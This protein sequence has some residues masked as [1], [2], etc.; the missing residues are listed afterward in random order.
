[1]PD[2]AGARNTVSQSA[3]TA[4]GLAAQLQQA[5]AALATERARLAQ[6]TAQGDAQA[7]ADA[8]A[9]IAGLAGQ[10]AE[11][12]RAITALHEST[13]LAVD[14]LLGR[15][16]ALEGQTPLVL[17]PVRI[18]TRSTIDG[19]ALRVRIYHDALHGEA[20]DEGIDPAE[21]EA[22]IAYWT[23]VWPDGDLA[24]PWPALVKAVGRLRAP[25]VAE[26]L[27]PKNLDGRPAG[28][29]AFRDTNPR[30]GRPIT[31]RTLPD[32]FFVRVEQQ[33][34][35]PVTVAGG[36]IPDELPLGLTSRDELTP[37]ELDGQDLPPID[38]SLRWLVDF[39]EAERV[40][41]AVTVPLPVPGGPV[42]RVLVY[43]VRAA[44]SPADGAARLERMIH[45]HRFSDGAMFLAQGTP[46]N[47]TDTVRTDF[48]RRLDPD[49]PG[50]PEALAPDSNAAVTATALGI[51]QD[52]LA[53]LSGAGDQEQGRASA[54]NA[55]LWATTWGDAIEYLT[56]QGRANGDQR[57]DTPALEAVRDHWVAH[58]RG[59]GPLPVLRLGRQPY[60]LLPLVE[61]GAAWQP[62]D[63][64][65][66]ENRLVPFID[67]QI[68]W[69][70]RDADANTPTVMNQPLEQGLKTILGTDAVLRGLR[71]RTALS[72]DSVMMGGLALL[73]PDLGDTASKQQI[74]QTVL[75]LAGIPN[76][77]LDNHHLLGD[78]TR[79][80]ALALVDDTDPA[81]VANLL[82]D[83]PAP[84]TPKSVLQVLLTHADAV[85]RHSR[86][87]VAPGDA[88]G[89]LRQVLEG[90]QNVDRDLAA[91]GI[92]AALNQRVGDPVIAAAAKAVT[93]AAGRL[94]LRATADLE[95]IPAHAQPTLAQQIAGPALDAGRLNG[96]V[97][98]QLI[99]ELLHRA[100]WGATFRKALQTIAAV[101]DLEERRLLLG[102]TLDC[103][104]H[105]LDAW[106]TA[107]ATRRLAD[108]RARNG[109]GAFLGAYGWVQDFAPTVPVSLG[110]VDGHELFQDPHDGG[111]IHAP[112][113]THAVTAGVLRSARLTHARNDPD[114]APLDMD[115]SSTRVRDALSL[116]EGMRNGQTLSALLGYRLERRLHENQLERFIYVL[117]ALA[118]TRA[119]KL[120][121][122]GAPAQESLA[123]R[124]VVDGLRLLEMFEK[125]DNPIPQKLREGPSDARYIDRWNSATDH[126]VEAV[127]NLIGELDRTH[128]AVADLL[129]AEAVHQ[130]VSGSP[131]R[132][133][134]AMDSLGSG[135]SPPPEPDVSRT[136]RSGVPVDH[137]LAVLIPDPPVVL[138][139][140]WRT[141]TP[142]AKAEPRLDAWARDAVGAPEQIKIADGHPATLDRAGLSA[143][144]VLYDADGDT[145]GSSTLSARLRAAIP[146]LPD[147]LSALAPTWELAGLLRAAVL[148]GRPLAGADLGQVE[149]EHKVGRQPDAAELIDRAQAALDALEGAATIPPEP[150][151]YLL[152]F[153][154]RPPPGQAASSAALVKQALERTKTAGNLITRARAATRPSVAAELASQALTAIFGAGFVALPK[155]LPPPAGEAD[156]WA[157]AVGPSGITAKPGA[158]IRPW[159]ARQSVL[160]KSCANVGETLLVREALGQK[161]RL[162]V[163]QSPAGA[164]SGWVGLPFADG[165]PP[166]VPLSSLVAEVAG[167][168][169]G[170]AE[171]ALDG[172]LAGLVFDEWTEVIP[173]RRARA[174][175]PDPEAPRDVQ[176]T[177]LALNANAPGARPPQAI[178]IAMSPDGAAWTSDRLVAALDEA[179]TLARMRCVTLQTL[180]SAGLHLPALYFKDWSLQGEP[181]IDWA[182]V[183]SVETSVEAQKFLVAKE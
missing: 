48:T 140:A 26:A 88:A 5:A 38:A 169:L 12:A 54:F 130:L 87:S 41:M 111:F 181:V 50:A 82:L 62:L 98:L 112:S 117:R 16:L 68:R 137:R 121:D 23:A 132:A 77:A 135:E 155:I 177:G 53:A 101:G 42:Q 167:A 134:A 63:G 157:G 178:L 179:M 58:V 173:R 102:E 92:D 123:A 182:G 105:R 60:G 34:A 6:L 83:A 44:L 116:L 118:P 115:L 103:C 119:G 46:T 159:L 27:K 57:L 43:G 18:E 36:A 14:A 93:S 7:I 85:E 56:P 147:D 127:L 97:G 66:I 25:W 114:S 29:P 120:T 113:L 37:L 13:R 71:V 168:R 161:P 133:A 131:H 19:T 99:G 166:Q 104:S 183:R 128:D 170:R 84:M 55:A 8:K 141:D 175:L 51:S 76:D 129:L 33:G 107:A 163:A 109:A 150:A 49:P 4:A 143:L 73:L 124:D 40:G 95:P 122:P 149:G 32:R 151:P 89:A 15:E 110:Q 59:R 148:S 21:R 9:R 126:E 171:P 11:A 138:P 31:A 139:T 79:A 47:N 158:E 136:P 39:A 1:M 90:A 80:L 67:Q 22:G 180:P 160:R 28:D 64:D 69:M 144:D 30:M 78:K 74:S 24:T 91:R 176:T 2:L 94:D 96:P 125:P 20:L 35:A 156:P 162:R 152:A 106:I 72:P 52:A 165:E 142:R 17:L 75:L 70:W 65:F 86:A 61:T 3:A 45:A 81:F 172:A 108:I 10:R 174:D 153:G 100:D 154:V 146:D 145:V 164:F